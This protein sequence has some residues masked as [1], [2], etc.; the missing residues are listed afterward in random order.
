MS[1][2]VTMTIK[3]ALEMAISAL[4]TEAEETYEGCEREDPEIEAWVQKRYTAIGLL[5]RQL[6]KLREV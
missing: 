2:K 6:G 4:D 5:R 3:E 1:V